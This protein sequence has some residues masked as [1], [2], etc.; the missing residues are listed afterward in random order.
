MTNTAAYSIWTKISVNPLP[1]K[2]KNVTHW[3]IVCGTG[4]VEWGH[5]TASTLRLREQIIGGRYD[6]ITEFANLGVMTI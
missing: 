1:T 3:G 6:R 2:G 5:S 4:A